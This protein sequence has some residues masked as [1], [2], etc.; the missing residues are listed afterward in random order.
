MKTEFY[1]DGVFKDSTVA[2]VCS[3]AIDSIYIGRDLGT[4]WQY[5][6]G[7]LDDITVYGKALAAAEVAKPY[8]MSDSTIHL[9]P[10]A[11]PTD[12]KRPVFRWYTSPSATSYTL[13]IDTTANL[14]NPFIVAPVQ[15][16][17]YTP[18]IDLPAGTIYWQV[19]GNNGLVS[20]I[21]SFVIK[22]QNVPVPVPFDPNLIIE[23]R[24]QFKWHPVYGATSYNLDIDSSTDFT[25]TIISAP[26]SDTCYT[27]LIDLPA[28]TLY[29]RVKSN[30][31]PQYSEAEVVHIQPDSIP[32]LFRFNGDTVNALR[33]DFKWKPVSGATI[34][35]I[36]LDTL[37]NFAAPFLS[38]P[39]SDT[40][41]SPSI[42]L[43][44]MKPYWHVSS[45]RAPGVFC[46]KDSLIVNTITEIHL[47]PDGNGYIKKV[48][49]C[50]QESPHKV[51]I[52]FHTQKKTL[53]E[54]AIYSVTGRLVRRIVR[55]VDRE[56]KVIFWDGKDRNKKPVSA[57]TY[58]IGI[59]ADNRQYLQKVQVLH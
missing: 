56:N 11:S 24:P 19:S 10:I 6:K 45:N 12:Q 36:E 48:L 40:L 39:T 55:K 47:V 33:P 26:V 7:S 57:G 38:V 30:L 37:G 17:T 58:I 35:Q 25:T 49:N 21:S 5:F 9:I 18:T 15:D 44:D 41:Y 27:P 31:S 1:V 52:V 28:V 59:K 16:T 14:A 4:N 50:Y 23:V 54:V 34:Y 3:T 53:A 51:R 13:K 22:D 2:L 43:W 32:F 29:R 46:L 8:D 20:A 42:D